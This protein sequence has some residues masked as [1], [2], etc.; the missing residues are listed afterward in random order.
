MD[1]VAET[2]SLEVTMNKLTQAKG[3]C[4]VYISIM[5][6]VTHFQ[7]FFWQSHIRIWDAET[8]ITLAVLALQEYSLSISCLA[9]SQEVCW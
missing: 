9:F 5:I 8:L 4:L 1:F 7:Y 3:T 2:S 6:T